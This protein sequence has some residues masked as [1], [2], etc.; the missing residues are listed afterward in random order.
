[1]K[2]H[3][4]WRALRTVASSTLLGAAAGYAD[5]RLELEGFALAGRSPGRLAA[6]AVC[7]GACALLSGLLV[8]GCGWAAGRLSGLRLAEFSVGPVCLRRTGAGVRPALCPGRPG[9][10]DC[11]LEE[12]G[13]DAEDALARQI[14]AAGGKLLLTAALAALSLLA[15]VAALPAGGFFPDAPGVCLCGCLL[16]RLLRALNPF[17]RSELRRLLSLRAARAGEKAGRRRK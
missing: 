11:R 17:G 2:R 8:E 14:G 5:A 6:L 3:T 12:D 13:E 1:M 9:R 7:L 16:L 10:I 15:V 4:G